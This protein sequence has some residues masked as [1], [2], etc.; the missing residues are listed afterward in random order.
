[1]RGRAV[2]RDFVL[3]E[4][5]TLE[6]VIARSRRQAAPAADGRSP[7]PLAFQ[8]PGA[9]GGLAFDELV[10]DFTRRG[11]EIRI[12][13]AILRG[14]VMGGTAAGTVDLAEGRVTI[15]GTFIPAYGVNNLFGRLPVF[16]QILGGGETGGLI[17]VTFRLA[18]PLEEPKLLLNPISAIAP[19]IFRR[20]FEFR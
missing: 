7:L 12:E 6:A 5:K 9:P 15:S 11:D 14:P 16:G 8:A 18:G 20:I 3:S 13:E 19:G 10:I 1:M 4:E 17:G 2:V